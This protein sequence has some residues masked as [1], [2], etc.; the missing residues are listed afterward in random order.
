MRGVKEH[1]IKAMLDGLYWSGVYHLMA[2]RT[3]GLGV[4][5]MLHRVRPAP[6][7]GAFAPNAALE[8]TPD[9][10]DQALSLMKRR[11]VE[12]VD[13]DEAAERL[14][15]GSKSRFAVFT[16]DDGYADNLNGALPVFE[17]HGAPF[18]IYVTTGLI[19]GTA[20]IWWLMLEEA[21]AR[22]K[23]IRTRIGGRGFHLGAASCAEKQVAWD[24]IYWPLRDVS[25]T[26]RRCAV[27]TLA[28]EAGADERRLFLSIAP[29]W[30]RLRVAASHKLIRI[31]AHTLTHP[32][33]SAL[34]DGEARHEIVESRRRI[35]AEIGKPVRHFAYPF[36]DHSS[37]AARD[38]TLAR[39]AGFVTAV[40]TRRGPLFPGHAEHLHALPRVSLNGNY[41][42]TRYVDLF[43]SGA[44]FA[45][46]N[47]GNQLDVA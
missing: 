39:E 25:I 42:A 15:S 22:L 10:L 47:K 27:T 32:P 9:F 41:Q 8:V 21:I 29:S 18:T 24:T 17:A 3:A 37:A 40:T 13:L 5:F 12:I 45:L 20:D 4:I 43:L 33:L 11:G 35:E 30:E 34:N 36:G 7:K 38:F 6:E 19:D 16:F 14:T 31:G 26:E 1:V 23:S 2:P 46:W 28:E 44:P